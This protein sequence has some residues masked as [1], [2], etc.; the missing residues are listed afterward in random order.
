MS[1]GLVISLFDT[2]LA[3]GRCHARKARK[4]QFL[5]ACYAI[6]YP[7]LS[8]RPSLHWSVTKSIGPSHFTLH[9]FSPLI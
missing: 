9:D 2:A 3:N 6:L 4:H 7:T 1:A 8:V 5:V